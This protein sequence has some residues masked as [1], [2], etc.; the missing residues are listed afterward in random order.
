MVKLMITGRRRAGMTRAELSRHLRHVHGPMVVSSPPD[1]G[2]MPGGYVQN[3]VQDGVYPAGGLERDFVTE[4]WFDTPDAARQSV[5]TPYY[6]T[7]LRPDEPRFVNLASVQRCFAMETVIVAG[8][9]GTQKA[10]LFWAGAADFVPAWEAARVAV[11]GTHPVRRW[12]A[13]ETRTMPGPAPLPY[14]GIDEIWLTDG[15]GG[16]PLFDAMLALLGDHADPAG[17]FFVTAEEFTTARLR[18]GS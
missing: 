6:E 9:P 4:V 11:S 8:E 5:M 17:C 3:H 12:V 7:V 2:A 10:F 16:R 18:A 1:A 15:A 14:D 13:N